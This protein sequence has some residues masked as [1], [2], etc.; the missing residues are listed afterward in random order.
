M[1][2]TIKYKIIF[3][4]PTERAQDFKSVTKKNFRYNP[5]FDFF[6]TLLQYLPLLKK[7]KIMLL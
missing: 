2:Y 6:K 3:F 4:S 7:N 1:H 5:N